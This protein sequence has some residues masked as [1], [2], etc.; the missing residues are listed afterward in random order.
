MDSGVSLGHQVAAGDPETPREPLSPTLGHT[1]ASAAG[2]WAA[3]CPRPD[4]LL[5][6]GEIRVSW[7]LRDIEQDNIKAR[8]SQ[9]QSVGQRSEP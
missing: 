2:C 3:R 9:V 8:G 6:A 7:R 1:A 5:G 4:E